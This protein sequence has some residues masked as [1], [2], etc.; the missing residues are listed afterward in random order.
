V[1]RWRASESKHP[2]VT[3]P[4]P[5]ADAQTLP[6]ADNA[7]DAVPALHVPHHMGDVAATVQELT[8]P[9]RATSSSGTVSVARRHS[10]GVSPP[11]TCGNGAPPTTGRKRT[12]R[13]PTS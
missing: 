10:Y 8:F 12:A 13:A 2:H 6:F 5:V 4:V 3:N 7:A 9:S 1:T 11:L